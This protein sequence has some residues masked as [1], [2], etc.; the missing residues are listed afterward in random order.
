MRELAGKTIGIV[1][2]G[3]IGKKVAQIAKAFDMKVIAYSRSKKAADDV[4]FVDF[5]TL[6]A[7]SDIVTVHCPLNEQSEH[8]FNYE[9]FK[10]FKKN[11]LQT[12]TKIA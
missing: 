4:E 2:Y 12:K 9:V 5:E 3:A 6:V 1:G 7:T 8:L 11:S 10:K